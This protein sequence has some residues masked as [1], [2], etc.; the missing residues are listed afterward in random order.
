[1][2]VAEVVLPKQYEELFKPLGV[3]RLP[4]AKGDPSEGH[5]DYLKAYEEA[6][7][8]L[9]PE[10]AEGVITSRTLRHGRR[11]VKLSLWPGHEED[12]YVETALEEP[13][14]VGTHSA[15]RQLEVSGLVGVQGFGQPV[16]FSVNLNGKT[17]DQG[18]GRVVNRSRMSYGLVFPSSEEISALGGNNTGK[19]NREN[20][21]YV[22]E[23]SRYGVKPREKATLQQAFT[24]ATEAL[25]QLA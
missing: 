6:F 20:R 25:E 15:G 21:V 18:E 7:D 11:V 8:V 17:I 14:E 4:E 3:E 22:P 5:P 13:G 12:G 16:E 1:M 9:A 23:N 10:P 24:V 19:I 2:L